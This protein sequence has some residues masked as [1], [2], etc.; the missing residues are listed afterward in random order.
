M[1]R[2]SVPLLGF[3]IVLVLV[4]DLAVV[5][6]HWLDESTSLVTGRVRQ[7]APDNPGVVPNEG[8]AFVTGTVEKVSADAQVQPVAAPFTIT[9]VE[10]GA[11]RAS[12]E[13]ALVGGRRVTITWDGGTPLPVSGEGALEL[14]KTHVEVD[15][16]GVVLSLD[17]APR[18]FR[19]GTY[20]LG[21]TVA[22]GTTGVATPREGVQFTA[23]DQT[24]LTSRGNV[25]IREELQRIDMLGP[26]QVGMAGRLRVQFRDRTANAVTAYLKEGPYRVTVD[27]TSGRLTVDAIL[28]GDVDLG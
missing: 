16:N 26:G 14:G 7:V 22:V 5:G 25:V 9:A 19:P 2:S 1:Q 11:G 24:V 23:D 27:P 28:Q 17:G 18:V 3:L 4:A 12:I 21:A 8:Q 10:R 13:N 15:A 20:S 6:V